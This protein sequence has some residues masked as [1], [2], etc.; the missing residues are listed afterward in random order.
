MFV[1]AIKLDLFSSPEQA[2]S[3]KIR[4]AGLQIQRN[5]RKVTNLIRQNRQTGFFEP[6]AI[7]LKF[8]FLR[9][10]KHLP[11]DCATVTLANGL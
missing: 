4:A 7:D 2:I 1:K 8:Q 9:S 10:G 3:G 6:T 11:S 5:V